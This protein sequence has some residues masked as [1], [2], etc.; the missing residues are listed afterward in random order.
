MIVSVGSSVCLYVCLSHT[1][2]AVR[3][4]MYFRFMDDV[5]FAHDGHVDNVAASYVTA[6]SFA[7]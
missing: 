3:H 6:S 4:V 5:I 2:A 7:G 1:L